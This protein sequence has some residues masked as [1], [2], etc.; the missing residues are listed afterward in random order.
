MGAMLAITTGLVAAEWMAAT[1]RTSL[2]FFPA[3]GGD[4]AVAATEAAS[5]SMVSAMPEISQPYNMA[6]T[7]APLTYSMALKPSCASC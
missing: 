3:V 7:A 4:S 6:G 1:C 5:S 2:G